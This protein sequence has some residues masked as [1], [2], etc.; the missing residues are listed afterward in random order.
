MIVVPIGT[1]IR[2]V[3]GLEHNRLISH[4]NQHSHN[5]SYGTIGTSRLSL[6]AQGYTFHTKIQDEKLFTP[7]H[8]VTDRSASRHLLCPRPRR[9]RFAASFKFI[10]A[11]IGAGFATGRTSNQMASR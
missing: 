4:R 7:A 10:D 11:T 6:K 3:V 9:S 5:V 1:D 8:L 2:L